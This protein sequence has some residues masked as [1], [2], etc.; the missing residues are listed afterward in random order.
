MVILKELANHFDDFE[1][2]HGIRSRRSGAEAFIDILLEFAPE[3]RA[4]DIQA[5]AA[6]LR[7]RIES[8]IPNSHVTIGL[9][10]GPEQD[11]SYSI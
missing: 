3:R 1:F 5:A 6:S 11:P 7:R 9:S 10:S 2:L 4:G 8:Q